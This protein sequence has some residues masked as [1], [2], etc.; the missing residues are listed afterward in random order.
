MNQFLFI[1]WLR[2]FDQYI[3]RFPGRKVLLLA[4]NASCHGT[5]D[6]L[7]N[8]LNVRVQFLPPNTTSLAQPLDGGIIASMKKRFTKR[9]IHQ[10]LQVNI[11]D[12]HKEIYQIDLLTAIHWMRDIWSGLECSVIQNCWRSTGLVAY[13]DVS[14][15]L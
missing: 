2:Q 14:C 7:P 12:E 13:P 4:G 15:E 3:S 9:Q 6:T 8:L 10:V 11:D 1:K 5:R